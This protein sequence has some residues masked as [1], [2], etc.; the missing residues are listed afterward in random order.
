MFDEAYTTKD[1]V[2]HN[3]QII[4]KGNIVTWTVEGETEARQGLVKS[5]ARDSSTSQI[6]LLVEV[7]SEGEAPFISQ[8][9]PDK[10]RLMRNNVDL[11]PHVNVP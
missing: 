6:K 3:T 1:A 9:S 10:V 8:I 4:F 2:L 5:A 7:T 11:T